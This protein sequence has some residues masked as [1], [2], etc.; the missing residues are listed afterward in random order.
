[1]V[2]D[3][4]VARVAE[5]A[6]STAERRQRR[7]LPA[8]KPPAPPTAP[9]A[10]RPDHRSG[11]ATHQGGHVP[12]LNLGFR[13]LEGGSLRCLPFSMRSPVSGDFWGLP[14]NNQPFCGCR[15]PARTL[16]AAASLFLSLTAKDIGSQCFSRVSAPFSSRFLFAS[17]FSHPAFPPCSVFVLAFITRLLESASSVPARVRCFVGRNRHM[18]GAGG[19]RKA[20][21][22]AY[23]SVAFV[24]PSPRR[25]ATHATLS[26]HN[27]HLLCPWLTP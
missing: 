7:G 1:M 12:G 5:G 18:G 14:P 15:T 17:F 20:G 25:L 9:T 4:T 3:E 6:G 2:L 10:T 26:F 8:G 24:L 23:L 16:A 21:T 13:Y 11:H 19:A 22:V 27:Q